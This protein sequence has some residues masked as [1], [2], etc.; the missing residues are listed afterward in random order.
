MALHDFLRADRVPGYDGV[1]DL[2]AFFF[3]PLPVF[4]YDMLVERGLFGTD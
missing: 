1:G 3:D 2:D 4:F